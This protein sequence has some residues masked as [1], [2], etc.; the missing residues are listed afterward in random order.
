VNVAFAAAGIVA[1]AASLL[2]VTSRQAVHGLLYFVVSL[3]AVALLL[4]QLGAPLAAALQVIVYAGAVVVLIVFVTM[5]LGLGPGAV[6][7]GAWMLAGGL[8]LVLLVEFALLF[9][10]GDAL[11]DQAKVVG[12]REVGTNLFG[13][14]V[15]GVELASMVLLAGLVG[16]CHVGRARQT[17]KEGT[18]S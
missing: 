11:S 5:M 3:L 15:L 14:Y 1:V 9:R 17:K 12:P 13:P 2:A 8:S 16:A 4:Y 10:H 6:S 7:G 18:T